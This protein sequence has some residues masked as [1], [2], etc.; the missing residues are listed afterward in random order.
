MLEL[1]FSG[2]CRTVLGLIIIM[3]LF[4]LL[5]AG[6]LAIKRFSSNF[7][8]TLNATSTAHTNCLAL[9]GIFE[10]SSDLPPSYL[11]TYDIEVSIDSY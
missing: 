5:E 8:L 4:S 7:E 10:T 6:G 2:T 9:I 3:Y 1:T 11:L